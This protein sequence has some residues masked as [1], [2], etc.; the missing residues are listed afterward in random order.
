MKYNLKI[1]LLV[2][3]ICSVVCFASAQICGTCNS[4]QVECVLYPECDCMSTI[5][6]F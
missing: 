5:L 1:L 2:F 6:K 3:A 4:G